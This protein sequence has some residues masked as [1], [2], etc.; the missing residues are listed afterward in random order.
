MDKYD[1]YELLGMLLQNLRDDH[2]P[3]E[4]DLKPAILR[5]TT[6][7]FELMINHD[8]LNRDM[9]DLTGLDASDGKNPSPEPYAEYQTTNYPVS[10]TSFAWDFEKWLTG[11]D[12]RE[13]LNLMD[14]IAMIQEYS[15]LDIKIVRKSKG[16]LV[17]VRTQDLPTPEL[18][19]RVLIPK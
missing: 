17:V 5:E 11:K 14:L 18:I 12:D 10:F 9:F 7:I 15:W 1:K 2:E 13:R 16:S 4:W 3:D 6:R 19:A 8:H